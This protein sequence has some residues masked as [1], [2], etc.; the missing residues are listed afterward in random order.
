MHDPMEGS[1]K[2][3]NQINST[4][5]SEKKINKKTKLHESCSGHFCHI[6]GTNAFYE[7]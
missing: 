1:S 2:V 4:Q 5:Q 7:S 6:A 3:A